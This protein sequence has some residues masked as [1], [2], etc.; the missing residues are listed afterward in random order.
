MTR[1]SLLFWATLSQASLLVLASGQL[2]SANFFSDIP[3]NYCSTRSDPCCLLRKDDCSVPILG[4][5][6]YCD[7]FC[8]RVLNPDCC[9][10]YGRVCQGVLPTVP[11]TLVADTCTHKGTIFLKGETVQDNCNTCTCVDND[12]VSCTNDECLVDPHLLGNLQDIRLSW[13]PTNYSQFW[14]RKLNEGMFLRTGTMEPAY[15]ANRFPVLLHYDASALPRQFDARE[16]WPGLVGPAL[17]QGWCASSWAFS[18]STVAS[19][20]IS[21]HSTFQERITLSAQNLLDC[22]TQGQQGCKGGRLQRAWN[23][24]RKIGAVVDGCYPY[25]SGST[26]TEGVCQVSRGLNMA[27][28]RCAVEPQDATGRKPLYKTEP[29]HRIKS[30]ESDIQYE[31]LSDGPVQAVMKVRQDFFYYKSGIYSFSGYSDAH[32]EHHSVRLI[33]WGE[34]YSPRGYP[35]KYWLAVNSWGPDWGEGGLFRILRGS[36]ESGI[37]EHI[38]SVRPQFEPSRRRRRR[39]RRRHFHH[40]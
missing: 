35:I 18:T 19:D 26:G 20:R 27:S 10:D 4:T 17:D 8:N 24:L 14:G 22:N 23:F 21:I 16:Q 29:T 39:R 13:I 3:G 34:E 9:P 32:V 31:I 33:G 7:E 30:L 28:A 2:S 37:E 25:T 12:R 11:P 36:N 38:L 40:G 6:C 5:L 15:K 1:D